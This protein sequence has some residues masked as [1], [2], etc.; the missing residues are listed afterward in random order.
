MENRYDGL[1][2]EHNQ[3]ILELLPA[4]PTLRVV[5]GA[6]VARARENDGVVLE[7]G[8]GEG[9]LTRYML[10]RDSRLR[11][12]ALD[13]SPEMIAEARKKLPIDRVHLIQ[14][15]ALD[16]MRTSVNAGTY[17][18]I[19]SGWTVHNFPWE[20]KSELFEEIYRCL[21]PGGSMVLMDKI[22]PDDP[23]ERERLLE[24]QINRLR[25]LS[26]PD[27]IR[28]MTEHERQDASDPYRMDETYTVGRLSAIGFRNIRVVDRV[29]REVV[30]VGEK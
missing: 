16:Y 30:L 9:D 7:I 2:R 15:D 6:E 5:A 22:Y 14:A 3:A 11:L 13:I 12:D 18:V 21:R 20:E 4:H 8:V 27:A 28:A 29:E 19:A 10:D 24:L 17:Q 26:S 23:A 25:Y 1:L